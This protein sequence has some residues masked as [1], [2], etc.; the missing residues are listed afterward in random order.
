MPKTRK[1]STK[2]LE[3]YTRLDLFVAESLEISRNEAQKYIKNGHITIDGELPKKAGQKM[4]SKNSIK[5]H[6]KSQHAEVEEEKKEEVQPV[7]KK[8]T[9]VKVVADEKDFLVVVKPAGLLVHPT[10]AMEK[11][12]LASWLLKK[13]PEVEGVG[14]NAVRPGIVHRLDKEASGLLVVAKNQSMYKHLKKQFQERSVEKFYTVLVHGK[15]EKDHE[16]IDFDIDRGK[17]GKMVARPHI[18]KLSLRKVSKQQDGKQ[19]LSE[20]WVEEYPVNTT[21]LRVKIHSGRTHQIRVHMHAYGH[22]VV[23]DTLYFQKRHLKKNK[24]IGRLFLHA[25]ELAFKDKK[26]NEQRFTCPLPKKLKQKLEEF[27]A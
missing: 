5:V 7:K 22:P 18:D 11:N 27:S 21:L 26:G 16:T 8:I 13:Y 1:L 2:K 24:S 4:S 10:E 9:P 23:G 15:I 6:A 19:S 20:F 17:D 14:E 3:G 25:T 12:T